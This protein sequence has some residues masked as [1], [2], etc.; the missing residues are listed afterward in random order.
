VRAGIAI[1]LLLAGCGVE[2]QVHVDVPP[3]RNGLIP[4]A[5]VEQ[6]TAGAHLAQIA[7][8]DDRW[9]Y[10][11]NSNDVLAVYELTA[12]DPSRW[13]GPEDPLADWPFHAEP[14]GQPGLELRLARAEGEG[15]VRCTTLA[16]HAPTRSLYC[17]CDDG[18]GLSRFDLAV[19]DQPALES[20]SWSPESLFVRDLAVVGDHLYLARYD[21][22]L[23]RAAID[24]EGRLGAL[25]QLDLAGNVRRLAGDDQGRV[26]VL[27]V[28]RGL[29][30]VAPSEAGVTELAAL[31][32]A[33]P[34]LDL[35]VHG[36][37]A[38]VGLGSMGARVIALTDAGTLEIVA[39]FEPPGVVSA[40]D[41]RDDVAAVVSLTGAWLYDRRSDPPRLA[42]FRS[43]GAWHFEERN[44]SMLYARFVGDDLLVTDWSWVERFA[45]DPEGEATGIDI[46]RAVYVASEAPDV[47]VALRNPGG[48]EQRVEV[49]RIGGERLDSFPLAPFATEVRRYPAASF[50]IDVPEPLFVTV[51]DGDCVV[52]RVSTTVLRRP[53]ALDWPI[54]IQGHPA[55]GQRFPAIALGQGPIETMTPLWLP[56]PDQAQ[57]V[58]FYGSDCVAMWPEIEDLGWRSTSGSLGPGT[59]VLA[60]F[61]NVL[62]DGVIDRWA[63][64]GVPWGVFGSDYLGAG[65]IDLNPWT[66]LYEQGFGLHELPGA[67]YH[68]T[69][70]EIDDQGVVI[71]VE[72]EYRGA[73]E[74]R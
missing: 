27:T 31:P 30:V 54:A 73:H 29:L 23:S 25:E 67:A 26:W 40:V 10:V 52:A 7:T 36:R 11:A 35:A 13:A 58:V 5:Q 38:I 48:I 56:L 37:E 45:I 9:V 51:F 8:L 1:G 3:H 60:A 70:Y 16:V 43:S 66:D 41:L 42:G 18:R 63:L 6:P 21:R 50:E 39:S 59:V 15:E 44:G 47:E 68:P 22:G 24:D 17:A 19:P 32:L 33:G 2:P 57:R 71:A 12:A 20:P 55:P 64:A 53:P 14:E 49:V 62:T 72:R 69:D 28:D 74:L 4:V 65:L 61:E 34:A 46:E